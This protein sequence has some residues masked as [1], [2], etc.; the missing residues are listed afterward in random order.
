MS[1][2]RET[3]H[4]AEG[5]KANNIISCRSSILEWLTILN[6]GSIP[7]SSTV[8]SLGHILYIYCFTAWTLICMYYLKIYEC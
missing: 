4:S 7:S 1:M 8:K 6:E 5:L 2:T 3:I